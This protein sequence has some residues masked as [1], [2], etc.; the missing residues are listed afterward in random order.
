[1]GV[2]PWLKILGNTSL[3]DHTPLDNWLAPHIEGGG[4]V[5]VSDQKETRAPLRKTPQK[6]RG[7]SVERDTGN[8]FRRS[9]VFKDEMFQESSQGSVP[10][11]DIGV[12][13]WLTEATL[14]APRATC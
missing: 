9:D 3:Y 7:M 12:T 14:I 1:M 6:S 11:N 13:V 5:Y 8:I 2:D 4:I 10:L